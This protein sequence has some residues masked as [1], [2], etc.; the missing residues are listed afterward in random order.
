MNRYTI[1]VEDKFVSVDDV[2]YNDVILNIA[3][4]IHAVQWYGAYGEIEYNPVFDAELK[5][6]TKQP[7]EIFEDSTRFQAAL[8]AWG[9]A[10]TQAKEATQASVQAATAGQP[11]TSGTQTL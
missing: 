11:T 4:S 1:V 9:V 5:T 3:P 10:D 8:D 2:G 6:I 7:N